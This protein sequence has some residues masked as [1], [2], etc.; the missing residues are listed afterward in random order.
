MRTGAESHPLSTDSARWKRAERGV[1]ER[2]NDPNDGGTEDS[3]G[4]AGPNCIC[5]FPYLY[6]EAVC[7][8][9]VYLNKIYD[10]GDSVKKNY[11]EGEVYVAIITAVCLIAPTVIYTLYET[12][13]SVVSG[14]GICDILTK[15][16]SGLLLIPWQIKAHLDLIH[17][18]AKRVCSWRRLEPR[19]AQYLSELKQEASVL[20]FFVNFYSGFFGLLLRL[21]FLMGTD[22][23]TVWQFCRAVMPSLVVLLSFMKAVQRKDDGILS[24]ML[25]FIGWSCFCASR[26]LAFTLLSSVIGYGI[27]FVMSIHG[28]AATVIV[29][30]IVKRI[31]EEH[32][33]AGL[34]GVP[35]DTVLKNTALAPL[36]FFQ[37]GLPSLMYWPISFEL[38]RWKYVATFLSVSLA[39][40]AVCG[41]IWFYFKEGRESYEE[42][43]IVI[44]SALTAAAI[45]NLTLYRCCKPGKTD[46][47]VLVRVRGTNTNEYG[48]FFDFF[49]SVHILPDT[50]EYERTREK[51]ARP[52]I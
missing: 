7:H 45:V 18:A 20:E 50:S 42:E 6:I 25:S 9:I 39:E 8:L 13:R 35:E 36:I 28:L 30:R 33:Q 14:V 32:R 37:F 43:K 52:R 16:F 49:K 47:A 11:A 5:I 41:L 3:G 2:E 26:A 29:F 23:V 15:M 24:K 22:A 10:D 21:H 19:E 48:V 40:N 44:L 4:K 1:D 17:F 34:Q 51:L 38:K 31:H 46:L 27:L 12:L